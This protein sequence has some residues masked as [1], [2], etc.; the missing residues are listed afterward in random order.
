MQN[1][2]LVFLANQFIEFEILK[3]LVNRWKLQNRLTLKK[4]MI[5]VGLC[6]TII[7]MTTIIFCKTKQENKFE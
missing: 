7:L 1:F 4:K 3:S 5:I 2:L 6:V